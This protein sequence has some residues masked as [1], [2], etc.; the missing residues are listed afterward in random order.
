MARYIQMGSGVIIPEAE[1]AE[2]QQLGKKPYMG[3]IATE[4]VGMDVIN[5]WYVP[6]IIKPPQ[7][8]V[9][10]ERG[11][12]FN[13]KLYDDVSRD[14]QVKASRQQRELALIAKEWGVEPGDSSR[15]AK[16]AADRLEAL[17]NRIAW[18]DKTQKMVAAVLYGYSVAELMWATDGTEITLDAIKVRHRA[19]FGFFPNGELRLKTFY[20]ISA[21][22]ALDPGKFWAF[23]CGADYDDE[24]YGLGLGHY[25]Y[26]PVFFKKNGLRAWLTFLDKFAQPTAVGKYPASASDAEKSRL[27]QALNAIQ[28]S[29]SIRIP[30]TMEVELLQAARSGTADYTALY[31]RMNE[32]ITKVY[33]GH[34]SA[35]EATPGKLGGDHT[36]NDVRDDLIKADAD[37]VCGSFNR[38]VAKWLTYYNQGDGVAPPRVW[39]KVDPPM[40]LYALAKKD[41]LIF[42]MGY[43]PTLAYV[44]EK[45]EGE[46]EVVAPTPLPPEPVDPDAADEGDGEDGGGAP[47]PQPAAPGAP[48]EPPKAAT[49]TKF[50]ELNNQPAKDTAQPDNAGQDVDTTP[51]SAMTDLLAA[52][53]GDAIAGMVATIKGLLDK[54]AS[55]ESFRDAL[56]S[57]YGDLDAGE[58]VKIMSLAFS[59]ADLAGQFDVKEGG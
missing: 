24:H 9:L 51:V 18:D 25:L 37:L 7:D 19:R 56:L 15:A 17:L 45:Y 39:R 44:L 2:L 4:D 8:T 6:N 12:Y 33:V 32:A 43:R 10:R 55:L 3:E 48:G 40:D 26:W 38:T 52:D 59:V 30:E 20:T 1:Y 22:Q 31:D 41:K 46:Y 34:T 5:P 14:D 21:G 36:A 58:L 47:A 29:T 16:K 49:V 28:N 50:S 27:M 53:G 54:A 11:N 13:Y 57:A 23:A 35:T 42:D